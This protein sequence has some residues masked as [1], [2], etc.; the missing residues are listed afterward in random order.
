MKR[1]SPF[2]RVVLLSIQ[3]KV[4]LT[5]R[6]QP[7][8]SSQGANVVSDF[9]R[10]NRRR[11]KTC[12][13]RR[14]RHCPRA[15]TRTPLAAPRRLKETPGNQARRSSGG[16]PAPERQR[17]ATRHVPVG[18]R[19]RDGRVSLKVESS[20]RVPSRQKPNGEAARNR[21]VAPRVGLSREG[22]R[23]LLCASRHSAFNHTRPR[24]RCDN[25]VAL[26][27]HSP[28]NRPP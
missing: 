11:E 23:G 7:P 2:A 13:L 3:R 28:I 5:R 17:R 6:R 16:R 8:P 21:S 18:H 9:S 1:L 14:K 4:E 20:P 27:R 22:T 19:G 26:S 12:T 24:S 10:Q 25:S 15:S